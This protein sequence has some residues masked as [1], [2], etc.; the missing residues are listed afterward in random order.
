MKNVYLF[1]LIFFFISADTSAQT[2]GVLPLSGLQYYNEGITAK[3]IDVS[4][5]GQPITRSR[6]PEGKEIL[7]SMK[8]PTGFTEDASKKIYPAAEVSFL[9]PTG[10]VILAPVNKLKDIEK[11]GLASNGLKDIPVKISLKSSDLK[12]ATEGTLYLRYYDLKSKKQMRVYLPITIGAATEK[13][14][15]SK[16]TRL[17][18]TSDGSVGY[19]NG[20]VVKNAIIMIDTA[21]K[22]KPQNAYLSI[23]LPYITGTSM[24]EV[25]SGKNNVWVFDKAGN[26][27]KIN[28]KLLK[29]VGGSL[30]D[31]IV[32]YTVKVPFKLKSNR[33]SGY[34]IRFRWENADRSKIIDIVSSK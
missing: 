7:F 13:P 5:D 21:L 16:L 11:T 32:D 8:L 6:I 23:E 29:K 3:Y 14:S 10:Q 15:T 9:S 30:E 12:Y 33:A 22:V 18:P 17:I 2:N 28:D 1:I 4:I 24:A 20:M 26:E 31:N 27:I 19:S 34:T 25:L